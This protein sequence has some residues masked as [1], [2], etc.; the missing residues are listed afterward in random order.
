MWIFSYCLIYANKIG[1]ID[2]RALTQKLNSHWLEE[3]VR[4]LHFS[5]SLNCQYSKTLG[6]KFRI[7]E[8]CFTFYLG[9]HIFTITF[10]S[11]ILL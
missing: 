3:R 6:S 2:R 1:Q 4:H 8:L 10:I 9:S 11:Y 5:Y 7:A